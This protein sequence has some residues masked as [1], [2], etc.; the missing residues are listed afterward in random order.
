MAFEWGLNLARDSN[1]WE[2]CI[3]ADCGLGE[4]YESHASFQGH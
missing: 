2:S 1:C 3:E 4:M